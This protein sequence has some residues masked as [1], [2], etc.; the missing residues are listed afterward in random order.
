MSTTDA[1]FAAVELARHPGRPSALDV[2]EAGFT[3]WTELH[4]DRLFGDDRAILGGPA[5]LADRWVM[6]IGQE[7][8]R[9]ASSR[10]VHN[11]GMAHPEGYR[12]AQRLMLWAER[13]SLPV[14]CL[15]D[16]PAAHAGIGAEERG[17][18]LAI[19]SCLST[20][21][22]LR[23]PVVSVVLSEGGSGGALA[24]GLGDRVL[25]CENAIYTVAP[26]ETCA[27]IVWRDS[28]QRERAAEML[29][30][31]VDT[32]HELGLVDEL[33]VEPPPGAHA[34]PEVVI[35]A[36]CEAIDRHLD[37][38]EDIPAQLLVADRLRRH[39]TGPSAGGS[40]REGRPGPRQLTS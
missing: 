23:T 24:L 39:R 27:A 34:H 11:F 38:L 33:V 20:T 6:V 31:R 16:T 40:G 25:A 18:A 3:E 4:G 26:P 13:F 15:I 28:R 8:G 12:K 19:A 10:A 1:R 5:R 21:V 9:D 22:Q 35:Q 32:A 17:Q 29:L 37:E 2:I 14:V 7:K 36:L 30:P